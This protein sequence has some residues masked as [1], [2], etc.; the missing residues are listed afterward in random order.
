RLT[1]LALVAAT[2][3]ACGPATQSDSSD[4]PDAAGGD[5]ASSPPTQAAVCGAP[6]GSAAAASGLVDANTSFA[7]A[8]YGPAA[9][10]AVTATAPDVILSPFSLSTVLTMIDA[11]AAGAT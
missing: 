10:S 9:A 3:G 8:L 1:V 7:V 11:G 6:Q 2:V 4:S 5:D